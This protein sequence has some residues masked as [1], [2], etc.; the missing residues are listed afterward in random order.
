MKIIQINP[1]SI[2]EECGFQ[3][4][5]EIVAINKH[6][7]RDIIDY[8]FH[9]SDEFLEVELKRNGETLIFEIK[10][11][12]DEDLGVEFEEIKYRRCDNRCIF[13]FVDQNPRGLRKSLYF[14]DEDYRL[15]FLYGNYVTLTNVSPED[16]QRITEQRLSPIYV[17]V[18]S[19]DWK[20]R[21]FMLGIKKDDRLLDKIKFLAE[22]RIEI[23]AQIVL[24]PRINDGA[25]LIRTIKNLGQFYPHVKSV[26][27]VPV[28]LTR[29][30][31]NLPPL[32]PV[33]PEY[34]KKLIPEMD[35]IASKF[36]EKYGDYFVYLAD[37]FYLSAGITLPE[38]ERYDEFP[39]IENGV[40]MTRSFINQFEEQKQY[41]PH[42]ISHQQSLALITGRLAAPIIEKYI[43]T[44]LNKIDNLT[45]STKIIKNNFYGESITV[46]GLLTGQDI[47]EQLRNQQSDDILVLPVN[48]LNYDGL[49][50]DNWTPEKLS[51]KLNRQIKIIDDDFL[52]LFIAQQTAS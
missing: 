50:L 20:I 35:K 17:S 32:Q 26:A 9:V 21:H 29:H 45:V 28:G 49:F 8:R 13:C 1:D 38:S 42:R 43:V 22:N 44:E 6:P 27:I 33:T 39:Q 47:Y 18:H 15:S 23:H 14:K 48:S 41:L 36:R 11:D 52:S 7:I 25:S 31:E 16:L 10:K 46:T 34:A 12:F 51:Q 40:G 24:C 30:R 5:D 19:T 4:G 3:E 2:A 37:E